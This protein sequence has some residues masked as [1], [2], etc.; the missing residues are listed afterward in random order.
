MESPV[1]YI[2]ELGRNLQEM[3][4][5]GMVSFAYFIVGKPPEGLI[6]Q[7]FL[8]GHRYLT[9]EKLFLFFI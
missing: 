9:L 4:N 2:L 3:S 1:K 7:K 5:S 8:T 6:K